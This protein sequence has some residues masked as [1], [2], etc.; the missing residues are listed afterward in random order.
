VSRV[1][2]LAGEAVG[3]R[4]AGPA[5]RSWELARALSAQ[6]EVY[7]AAPAPLPGR[8]P[9]RTRLLEAT[10]G[11]VRNALSAA[12]VVLVRPPDL[13]HFPF[14]LEAGIPRV[15][16]LYDPAVIEDLEIHRALP[17]QERRD[18]QARDLDVLRRAA[19]W[20]DLFLCASE[21][22]RHFW[23]GVLAT[24]GRVNPLTYERDPTLRALLEVVPF[25]LPDFA[26]EPV[27]GTLRARFPVIQEGDPVGIWA[28]GVWNWFDPLTLIRAT[29][30]VAGQV[31][32]LRIVFLGSGHPSP[33]VPAMEMATRA[34]E[35]ARE[36]GVEGRNVLFNREWVPY[37]QRAA[38]LLDADF[39][40]ALH[41]ETV[42]TTFAFRTR[43]LDHL[44]AGL[45]SLVS[46][47]GALSELVASEGLGLVVDAEDVSG[48][49]AA[50]E[51]LATDGEL[52][53]ACRSETQYAAD[54]FRWTRV[55]APL[56]AYCSA[57]VPAPDRGVRDP[58]RTEA[59]AP[60]RWVRRAL[61]SLRTDGVRGFTA[62][63]Y[64]YARR[65]LG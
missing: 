57:P 62:R 8:G 21:P 29:A 45:P 64:R 3:E 11:A 43:L 12:D 14:L 22:Q 31:P 49:A 44:W 63:T 9:G 19:S 60:A 20:G 6:H 18:V 32:N 48:V 24:L 38:F 59:H 33:S 36:L 56:L 53:Q 51:R 7:L 34:E 4:M 55:A 54:R 65:R 46:R 15:V 25:G 42:E 39:A 26:P 52:R 61:R 41:F 2:V 5:I 35:L 37:E 40:V 23:L 47:G 16:D 13:Q 1:L 10:R 30:E 58:G 17:V 27:P 28:G 50:L